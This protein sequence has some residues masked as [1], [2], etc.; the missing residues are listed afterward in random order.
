[1]FKALLTLLIVLAMAG[2]ASVS[3]PAVPA[4]PL[5]RYEPVQ[6]INP[7]AQG[8]C[9]QAETAGQQG[10]ETVPKRSRWFWW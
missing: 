2:C 9:K 5:P 1:M 7:C 4:K 3:E 6:L 10:L 8:G